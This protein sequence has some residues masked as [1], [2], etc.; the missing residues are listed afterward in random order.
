MSERFENDLVVLGG[1][2][3][4]YVG[5]IRGAQ[6]GKK[7]TLVEGGAL[8]G[9]CLNWGCIPTKALLNSADTLT[10]I[11]GASEH[12]ITVDGLSVDYSKVVSRSRK[13][14]GRL[15]DGVGYLMKKNNIEVVS[16]RGVLVDPHTVRVTLKD[17]E[18][19]DVTGEFVVLAT[20]ARTRDLPGMRID[21]TD[22]IGSRQA[23]VLDSPPASLAVV[24]SGAIGVEMAHLFQTFGTQVHLFEIMPT[25]VPAA[26]ADVGKELGRAFKKRGMKVHTGT[27]IEG[28]ERGDDGLTVSFDTGKKK[29][30]VTVEKVLMAVGVQ[31]N[32]EEIGLE[33]CGV[34]QVK[35]WIKVDES[36]QTSVAGVYAI[37]DVIGEPCLAHAAS[38]EGVRA[39]EH[40]FG[41]ETTPLD[42]STV[43]GCIYCKPQVASVGM[44]E[45][46]AVEAGKEIRIG[47]FPLSANGK[48]LAMGEGVG[49]VKVIVDAQYGEILGCHII[50]PEATE[51]I[52]ELALARSAEMTYVEILKTVHPHPTLSE[53]VMEAV[54]DAFHEALN[55]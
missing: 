55:I 27:T 30:T 9:I 11:K 52:T 38:A 35:G 10:A 8:G 53:A 45:A 1:G 14:S 15:S 4:G 46:Q 37:G 21:G 47:K 12:G 18:S 54:A 3:G 44:T 26:D 13:I 23:L 51:L 32:V 22:I 41:H 48:A 42:Y 31:P 5:A 36:Y 17:G 49:F 19:R 6:L 39:V 40:M 24:G 50:G 43:P 16:G 34:E 25:L 28:L 20:G 33:A 29:G 7:V 2:P